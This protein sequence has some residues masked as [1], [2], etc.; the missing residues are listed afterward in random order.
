[1]KPALLVIDVQKQFF[2]EGTE[3]AKSLDNAIEYI[4]AAIEIF[5]DKKLPVVFIQHKDEEHGL[6]P[7]SEGFDLPDAF[8]VLPDDL[9]IVKT[10]SNAFNK[11]GLTEQL[12]ALG[13]DTVIITGFCAEYCVLSTYRGAHDVD[14][15]AILLLGSLASSDRKNI[16]FV[17]KISQSISIGAL[18][19]FIKALPNA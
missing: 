2:K 18:D 11:T 3:T 6:L 19:V 16:R 15:T 4:S 8:K 9:Q 10:Y 17:E 1:M 5:R 14:L 12:A 13:V 7:G